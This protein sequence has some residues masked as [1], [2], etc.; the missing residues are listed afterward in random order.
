MDK[1]SVMSDKQFYIPEYVKDAALLGVVLVFTTIIWSHYSGSFLSSALYQ[2]LNVLSVVAFCFALFSMVFD[3]LTGFWLA[4][5][6]ASRHRL[7]VFFINIALVLVV[8]YVGAKYFG[9]NDM[10]HFG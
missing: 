10:V 2:Q 4:K 9:F 1:E 6:E 8:Y 5:Y 3:L 7:A